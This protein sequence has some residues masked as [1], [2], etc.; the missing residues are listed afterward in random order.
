MSV[1]PQDMRCEWLHAIPATSVS[2]IC[3]S[4]MCV[5]PL[6]CFSFQKMWWNMTRGAFFVCPSR[7]VVVGELSQL[8][9]SKGNQMFEKM[10]AENLSS[11]MEKDCEK[12]ALQVPEVHNDMRTIQS[13][14]FE[15]WNPVFIKIQR[16]YQ[17]A[18]LLR[19][20]QACSIWVYIAGW[21]LPPPSVLMQLWAHLTFDKCWQDKRQ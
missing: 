3:L 11:E 5:W 8:P 14:L 13:D 1:P 10:S 2:E 16:Q 15:Q 7:W 4:F 19:T 17:E 18:L 6:N 20:I 12:G 9:N 21:N